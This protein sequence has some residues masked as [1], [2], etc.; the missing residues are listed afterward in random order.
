MNSWWDYHAGGGA[1]KDLK[2]FTAAL[3]ARY[4]PSGGVEEFARKA[5]MMAYES[6][7][8]M[9]EALRTE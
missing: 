8:A 6:H 7:R 2:N 5:Q 4:G 9:F 1:F 3:D